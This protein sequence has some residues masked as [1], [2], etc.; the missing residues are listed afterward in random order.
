MF[1]ASAPMHCLMKVHGGQAS[2]E[3]S[4][5]LITGL[6]TGQLTLLLDMGG[7]IEGGLSYLNGVSELTGTEM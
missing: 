2:A 5:R 1:L 6:N 7:C 3:L 4:S